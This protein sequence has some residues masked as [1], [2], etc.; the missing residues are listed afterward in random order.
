M[1]YKIQIEENFLVSTIL[2]RNNMRVS[3]YLHY[4]L[5]ETHGGMIDYTQKNW[6]QK[7]LNKLIFTHW[8]S[9]KRH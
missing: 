3:L 2:H 1:E 7:Y 6:E 5:P 9:L 4:L 8:K